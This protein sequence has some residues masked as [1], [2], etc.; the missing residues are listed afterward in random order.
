MG[1]LEWWGRGDGSER[2]AKKG[3]LKTAL[4]QKNGDFTEATRSGPMGRKSCP[5]TV[6]KN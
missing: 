5:G 2:T 4:V 6:R 3:F 1:V